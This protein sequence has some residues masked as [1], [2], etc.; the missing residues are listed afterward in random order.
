VATPKQNSPEILCAEIL[1][2][3]RRTSEAI[4]HRAQ[5]EAEALLAEAA[6]E[7]AKAKQER[8]EAARAEAVR[9]RELI[10]ATVPIEA[11]R[12]RSARVE[13]LLESVHE[14]VRRRLMAHEGFDY[15]ET[16][17]ALAAEAMKHMPGS[18][19]VVKL[20]MADCAA[21][22]NELSEEIAQR[23]GRSPLSVTIA[24]ES[25]AKDGVCIIQDAEGRLVWD[26]SLS[27][28]LDRLWPEL[29]R[30]IAIQ[31]SLVLESKPGGGG[32]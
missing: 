15:R 12:L 9:R 4:I 21:L 17:I 25:A 23:V 3:A 19:F 32:A 31:T 24:K 1:A 10:L 13:A 2:D 6:T 22:G 11:G 30:Q 27:A 8:L 5:Q 29:R 20:S 16:I 7:A 28:R 14:E 26:N 18:A